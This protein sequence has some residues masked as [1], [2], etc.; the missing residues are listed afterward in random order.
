[1]SDLCLLNLF[2]SKIFKYEQGLYLD[3]KNRVF[4]KFRDNKELRKAIELW[5][6]FNQ[7][8]YRYASLYYINNLEM[9]NKFI[10]IEEIYKNN[11]I[12]YLEE[13][14]FNDLDN[15]KDLSKYKKKYESYG[16]IRLWNTINITDMSNLF[17]KIYFFEKELIK[18]WNLGNVIKKENM[19]SNI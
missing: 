1:M 14:P 16:N 13:I 6:Y 9:V 17:S 18:D 12:L 3:I 10:R 2:I 5:K 11:D 4:Y 15:I 7:N 19:F 8:K